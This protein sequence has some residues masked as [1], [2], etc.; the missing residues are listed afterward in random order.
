MRLHRLP[1]QG[2]LP[3]GRGMCLTLTRTRPAAL[4]GQGLKLSVML[5]VSP[6]GAA[7]RKPIQSLR[8]PVQLTRGAHSPPP[9]GSIFWAIA[10]SEDEEEPLAV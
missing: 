8:L 6:S 5:A 2:A 10:E 4:K 9:E 7:V 3:Q 1:R